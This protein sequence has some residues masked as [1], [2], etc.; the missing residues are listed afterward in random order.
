MDLLPPLFSLQCPTCKTIYGVKTGNQP[1]GKMEYHV[2]PHSLPGHPNCKTIRIIYN[3]PPGIQVPPTLQTPGPAALFGPH[4]WRL[5]PSNV[6]PLLSGTRAPES[7][8]ALHCQRLSPTLLPPR[9][10]ERTQGNHQQTSIRPAV[11]FV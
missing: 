7:R 6:A 10:R 2:I 1:A 3:I 8:E 4:R 9:Q 5:T 11:R